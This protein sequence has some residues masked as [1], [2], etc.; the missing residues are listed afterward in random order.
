[1]R[2][3]KIRDTYN[4]IN[5]LTSAEKERGIICAS[6]GNHAQGVAYSCHL[7]KIMGKIYM[8]K[9]I[10]KEK[11]VQLEYKLKLHPKCYL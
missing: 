11:I 2:S 5:S 3:F 9:N 10:S 7:L 1:M 4:K 6:A 8:P